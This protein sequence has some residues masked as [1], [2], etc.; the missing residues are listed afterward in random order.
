VTPEPD[1]S[2]VSAA[3][4]SGSNGYLRINSFAECNGRLYVAVGQHVYKRI[5][6]TDPHWRRLYINPY[7]GRISARVDRDP[8]ADR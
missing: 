3:G 8:G 1:L 6:G 7:P 4:I 2:T 5:D